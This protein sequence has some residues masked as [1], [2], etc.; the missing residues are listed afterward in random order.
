M[1]SPALLLVC[2]CVPYKSLKLRPCD[3]PRLHH[4]LAVLPQVL[5]GTDIVVEA[6]GVFGTARGESGVCEKEIG[7]DGRR[8]VGWWRGAVVGEADETEGAEDRCPG[9]VRLRRE[10]GG[11]DV[12]YCEG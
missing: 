11:R 9:E 8:G 3:L 1:P 6:E 7:D 4:L 12:H 2:V 5:A 10:K